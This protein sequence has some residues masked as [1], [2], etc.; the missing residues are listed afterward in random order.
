MNIPNLAYGD[1][2]SAVIGV[3][4]TNLNSAYFQFGNVAATSVSNFC[5][6]GVSGTDGLTLYGSG[7]I[8]TAKGST[9]DD[10]LG[11]ATILGNMTVDGDL[12]ITSNIIHNS[13]LD[14]ILLPSSG[15]TLAL[16]APVMSSFYAAFSSAGTGFTGIVSIGGGFT[17][18]SG[19]TTVSS[20]FSG[21]VEIIMSVTGNIP[22]GESGYINCAPAGA[23]SLVGNPYAY[24]FNGS[25]TTSTDFTVTA[26]LIATFTGSSSLA[27]TVSAAFSLWTAVICIRQLT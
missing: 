10:G 19:S 26:P 7:S 22:A 15:G 25:S 13:S 12:T 20:T 3:S 27:F 21:A 2:G 11:N 8:V 5:R 18:V 1:V 16:A 6:I 14:Q 17:S 24:M 23:S 4:N 9:L